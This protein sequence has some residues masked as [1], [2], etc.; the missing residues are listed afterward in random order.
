MLRLANFLW[1]PTVLNSNLALPPY[2]LNLF[3][4]SVVYVVHLLT[5]VLPLAKAKIPKNDGKLLL[6]GYE[7]A[8]KRQGNGWK[9]A[10]NGWKWL[11]MEI[12]RNVWSFWEFIDLNP[13]FLWFSCFFLWSFKKI[14][15]DSVNLHLQ[16]S[17]LLALYLSDLDS[18]SRIWI[19]MEFTSV[20]FWKYEFALIIFFKSFN[21]K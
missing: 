17:Y 14:F 18:K 3:K 1:M 6:N 8:W 21:N 10:W 7:M 2:C 5:P 19:E 15:R 16:R 12:A 20:I 13:L 11:K 4:G 9:I